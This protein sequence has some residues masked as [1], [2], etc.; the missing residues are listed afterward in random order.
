MI[1]G[2]VQNEQID[3]LVHQHT[4]PKPGLLPSG[5]RGDAFEHILPPEI[6]GRQ[7]VPRFLG[8]AVLVVEHGVH[9]IP[10]RVGEVN[11]LGQIA[12]SDGRTKLD[13]PVAG[14]L[15]QQA[16]DQ[17]GL[18][19]TI[20]PQQGDA[21]PALDQEVHIGK[22]LLLSEALGQA[23]GLKHHVSLKIPLGKGCL[24]GFFQRRLF[25]LLDPLHPVL[26][27]HGPAI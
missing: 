27:G 5:E 9:Q 4:Q 3:L 13:F 7:P 6:E 1:G 24:H 8:R 22:Q 16:A 11:D 10:L 21:L 26:D 19:R 2:L 15:I 14:L 23:L 18:S 12:E 17:G 25:R 20:V